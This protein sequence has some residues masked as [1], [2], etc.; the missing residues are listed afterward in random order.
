MRFYQPGREIKEHKTTFDVCTS[1]R[2]YGVELEL[3]QA[4]E[5]AS[6]NEDRPTLG[7]FGCKED[8]SI[9]CIDD[10]GGEFYSPILRGDKGFEVIDAFGEDAKDTDPNDTCGFHLH[11]GIA[12]LT[13]EQRINLVKAASL[14]ENVARM[15]TTQDRNDSSYCSGWVGCDPDANY[16]SFDDMIDPGRYYAFNFAAWYNHQTLEIRYH[17]ATKDATEVKNWI[18]LWLAFVD[19]IAN[20]GSLVA[21]KGPD[22]VVFDNLMLLAGKDV[23][24]FYSRRAV[25]CGYGEALRKELVSA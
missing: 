9:D 20:D 7:R 1:R 12:D 6:D 13:V 16:N 23:A 5:C 3:A 10:Y 2:T 17:H 4:Y 18:K 22:E 25:E 15:L 11:I 14:V 8:G 24:D 19:Y 21:F